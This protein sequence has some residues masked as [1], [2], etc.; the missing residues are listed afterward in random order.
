MKE[1]LKSPSTIKLVLRY[2]IIQEGKEW[3]WCWS[4][5]DRQVEY[6]TDLTGS[7]REKKKENKRQIDWFRREKS[8]FVRKKKKKNK[9]CSNVQKVKIWVEGCSTRAKDNIMA[10]NIVKWWKHKI[11]GGYKQFSGKK[12]SISLILIKI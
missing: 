5:V 1:Q 11:L 8:N 9:V 4:V 2:R 12:H 3:W 10:G 7:K 6:F